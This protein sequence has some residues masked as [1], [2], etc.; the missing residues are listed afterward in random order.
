MV[1]CLSL[2]VMALVLYWLLPGFLQYF[3]VI[4]PALLAAVVAMAVVCLALAMM[5]VPQLVVCL[6]L[7][8]FPVIFPALL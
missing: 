1:V 2:L 4:P 3:P 5:I 6:A 8:Y 7:Q